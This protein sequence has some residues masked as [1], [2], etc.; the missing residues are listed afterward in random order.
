[1]EKVE[2]I[3]RSGLTGVA[4]WLVSLMLWVAVSSFVHFTVDPALTVRVFGSNWKL[5]IFTAGTADTAPPSAFFLSPSLPQ[6]HD[7][8]T[9]NEQT[10]SG[11]IQRLRVMPGVRTAQ[12]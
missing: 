12:D 5:T 6:A 7:A 1:M 2:P 9:I 8:T 11:E 10:I 4:N 3:P